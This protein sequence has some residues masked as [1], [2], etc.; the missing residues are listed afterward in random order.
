MRRRRCIRASSNCDMS[1]VTCHI[2]SMTHG[3]V[4]WVGTWN[5]LAVALLPSTLDSC[6]FLELRPPL[7]ALHAACP[8]RLVVA[9]QEAWYCLTLTAIPVGLSASRMIVSGW[10]SSSLQC[11]PSPGGS[12]LR[13][14][15]FILVVLPNGIVR[16]VNQSTLRVQTV[17]Q[18]KQSVSAA[19]YSEF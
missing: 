19:A 11:P 15:Q 16:R 17:V 7:A 2:D 10:T 13:Q 18:L 5:H 6:H 14:H 12:L 4:L 1:H 3:A 9:T 8:L